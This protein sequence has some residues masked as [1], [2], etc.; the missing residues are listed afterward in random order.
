[1][2]VIGC[3]HGSVISTLVEIIKGVKTF[4]LHPHIHSCLVILAEKGRCCFFHLCHHSGFFS[5]RA[6][7]YLDSGILP[8]G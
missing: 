8:V 2:L 4:I 7:Q 1:M 5:S 3:C 6:S